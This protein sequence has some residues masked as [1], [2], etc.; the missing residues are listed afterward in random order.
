M[1]E[2]EER[3]AHRLAMMLVF[4]CI[5]IAFGVGYILELAVQPYKV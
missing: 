1:T 3:K 4:L 2:E 5:S